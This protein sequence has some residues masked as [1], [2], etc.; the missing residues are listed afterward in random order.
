MPW[1]GEEVVA[2][3]ISA[4]E[5][6]PVSSSAGELAMTGSR[7][8]PSTMERIMGSATMSSWKRLKVAGKMRRQEQE[9]MGQDVLSGTD[10]IGIA[11][12]NMIIH[13][14]RKSVF[15]FQQ[16]TQSKCEVE[17]SNGGEF[18]RF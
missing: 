14:P 15:P 6:F 2:T 18:K 7:E 8:G 12:D 16:P 5:S 3:M 1:D 9:A 17:E 4:P 13:F 10:F 11:G